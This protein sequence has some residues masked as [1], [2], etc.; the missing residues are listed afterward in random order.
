MQFSVWGGKNVTWDVNS[1]T[2]D[3][4]IE[5]KL[6]GNIFMK[7]FNNNNEIGYF[8]TLQNKTLIIHHGVKTRHQ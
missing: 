3:V 8:K 7:F 4:E 5:I 2:T 6:D 1:N